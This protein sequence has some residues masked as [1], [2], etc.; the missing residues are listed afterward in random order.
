MYMMNLSDHKYKSGFMLTEVLIALVVVSMLTTPMFLFIRN[1]LFSSAR[2]RDQKDML[3]AMKSFMT[4]KTYK[5]SQ[6]KTQSKVEEK[7]ST[8]PEGILKYTRN[9]VKRVGAFKN[10]PKEQIK[11][12]CIQTVEGT[13]GPEKQK[14]R[15]ISF[16]YKPES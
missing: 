6:D 9:Q 3:L 11:N 10:F 12:L 15:L 13:F 16:L 2:Y 1:A 4:N 7:K 14:G 8:N 5:A